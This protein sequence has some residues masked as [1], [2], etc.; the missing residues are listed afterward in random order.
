[1]PPWMQ[2][3]QTL[4]V[5]LL[6][7]IWQLEPQMWQ[8]EPQ[9]QSVLYDRESLPLPVNTEAKVRSHLA[10]AAPTDIQPK[11]VPRQ[12]GDKLLGKHKYENNVKKWLKRNK[13][14]RSTQPEWLGNNDS[15]TGNYH[16]YYG[17]A[18]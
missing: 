5:G 6:P 17:V 1:M 18:E 12:H 9:M 13:D 4:N 8:L 7:Q 15:N 10:P 11:S 16:A 3:S 2:Q 14:K